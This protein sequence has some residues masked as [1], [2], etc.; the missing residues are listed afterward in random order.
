[1]AEYAD[2][3]ANIDKAKKTIKVD[4]T[5]KVIEFLAK[6]DQGFEEHEHDLVRESIFRS[7]V[8]VETKEDKWRDRLFNTMTF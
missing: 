2:F 4:N 5:E 7:V 3:I 1:M 6:F 8:D